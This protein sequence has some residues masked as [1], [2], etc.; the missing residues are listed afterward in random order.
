MKTEMA[1]HHGHVVTFAV[2]VTRKRDVKNLS[3]I[4]HL[5]EVDICPFTRML[6]HL[7]KFK[8]LAVQQTA[9]QFG[10]TCPFILVH[11]NLIS[12]LVP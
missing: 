12:P 1:G 7:D 4:I 6:Y 5:K 8:V 3:I 11:G 2:R 9:G 10:V